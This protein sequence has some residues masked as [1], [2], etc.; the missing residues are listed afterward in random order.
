MGSMPTRSILKFGPF[1]LDPSLGELRKDGVRI[2]IQ[3]KPFLLLMALLERQGDLVTRTELHQRLWHGETFVDFDTGLNTAVRKLR[4]ALGD[5]SES[6]RYIETIPRRGYRLLHSA[7]ES[8]RDSVEVVN[9][10]SAHGPG[11][12]EA[13]A[14]PQAAA[15]RGPS[16]APTSVPFTPST[17]AIPCSLPISKIKTAIQDSTRP[18]RPLSLS[19]WSSRAMPMSFP[20]PG[21]PL[22]SR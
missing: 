11:I 3:E 1:E 6:P 5:E 18:S 22:C 12:A 8:V 13:P 4:A 17:L 7:H 14:S 20:D 10:K 9:G 15:A 19:A 16:D 21:F 2:P